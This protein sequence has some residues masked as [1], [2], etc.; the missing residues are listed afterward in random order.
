M[1]MMEERDP[2]EAWCVEHD[3]DP[4]IP[5]VFAQYMFET[6]GF[7][8]QQFSLTED[9]RDWIFHANE[10]IE[11]LRMAVMNNTESGHQEALGAAFR[12]VRQLRPIPPSL[13]VD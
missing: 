6:T 12:L 9:E 10:I 7:D 8:G 3:M 2:Y 1:T 11:W 5:E 13:T 4:E